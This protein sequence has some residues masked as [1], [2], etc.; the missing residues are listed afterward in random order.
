MIDKIKKIGLFIGLFLL[1]L[2]KDLFYIIPFYFLNIN[3]DKLSYSQEMLCSLSSSL[4]LIIIIFFIY[5]KYLI[6]KF[7]D[8]KKHFNEYFDFG[9]K[10]WFIGLIGMSIS[11]VLIATFTPLQEANNEVL[12]Q[13]MLKLSPFLSF[14]SA[15]ITAPFLEEMLFRK[16]FSDIFKNKKIMVIASGIV[17]GLLHVIFSIKTPWDLL[18]V[19]PYGFLGSSFAYI[20]YK[21]DNIYIP[22]LF[23]MIHNGIITLISILAMV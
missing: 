21:K 12:V 11:N 7:K 22:I 5:K 8:F 1:F 19:I 14:I 2:Y 23:H 13:E 9:I 15:S 20:L 16:S 17:F 4:I 18:Y 10:I 6:S 3:I